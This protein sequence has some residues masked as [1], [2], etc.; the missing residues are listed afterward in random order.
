MDNLKLADARASKGKAM[1]RGVVQHRNNAEGN[2]M[3]LQQMLIDKTFTTSKYTRFMIRDP[4]EREIFRLPYYPDRIVH[5]AIMNVLEPIFVA[6][7]TADTYSCIKGRGIHA[8]SNG[9]RRALRDE[10]ATTYCLQID[11]KKFY[12][13]IDHAILKQLLRRKIKD[14]NLLWLLDNIIDSAD[15]VPIGNYL[16]QYFAN[17]Y[18]SYFDHWIKEV[19]GVK[20]YFRYADD[21]VIPASN[22]PDLHKLLAAIRDYLKSNLNL[23]VKDNYQI[24]PVAARGINTLGYIHFHTHVLL[25]PRI[26]RRFAR[27]M[28]KRPN[29]ASRAAYMGWA[30]HCNSINLLNKIL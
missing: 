15:G 12:P 18:L 8:A 7:F 4:K 20:F 25:R 26:K 14:N 19:M 22:K 5:H 2:L 3:E 6:T 24:Y 13:S 16:S 1:Q 21:I 27:V 11:V 30:K 9:L 10:A 29:K 28:K 23:T 17:F